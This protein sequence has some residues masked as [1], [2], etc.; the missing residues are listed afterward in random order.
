MCGIFL[1]FS[2]KGNALPRDRCLSASKE[3]YNR[4]PD[5][6]KYNFF[7]KNTL[8]MSNTIL[9]ITGAPD[10]DSKISSSLKKNFFISFNGEI[11]NFKELCKDFIPKFFSERSLTDTKV[12]VNLHEKINYESIPDLLNGMFAYTVYDK[13]NDKLIIANDIQ[14][15]KSLY[16]S[17]EE[18]FFII[19]S[20]INAILK[21]K[22]NF[23]LN[24]DPLK[25]YLLTRHFMSN[26]DTCY[27]G[28]RVFENGS[29]NSYNLNKKRIFFSSYDNPL[30]WISEKKI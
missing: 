15:E 12:L 9:S 20:T 30:S 2:K 17:D 11:Y 4:G 19:S 3:L 16:Y 13:K 27:K 14:G 8:F 18:D 1:V 22:K 28:I 6:F 10:K 24:V 21:F 26:K 23:E 25:N 7:R 29:V 5:Y